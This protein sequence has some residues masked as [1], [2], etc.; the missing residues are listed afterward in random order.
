[1]CLNVENH[2]PKLCFSSI[3]KDINAKKADKTPEQ[4]GLKLIR[5]PCVPKIMPVSF[6]IRNREEIA[7][8]NL[9]LNTL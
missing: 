3:D 4:A 1:V 5:K 2:C 6:Y 8:W 9:F 7:D